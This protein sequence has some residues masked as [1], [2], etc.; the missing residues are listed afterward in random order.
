MLTLM[1]ERGG[2]EE[3]VGGGDAK[4]LLPGKKYG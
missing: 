3:G 1:A 2:E 4:M